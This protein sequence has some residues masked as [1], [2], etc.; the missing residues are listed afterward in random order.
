MKLFVGRH[1][2]TLDAKNRIQI[3]TRFRDVISAE[4]ESQSLY[5]TPGE[6][7][8][9]LSIFTERRFEEL[10][11]RMETEFMATPASRKFEQQFYSL[12]DVV[13]MDKQGRIVLPE[14]LTRMARL[15]GELA[16]VG[17]KHRIDVWSRG[18][19]EQSLGI[20]WEGEEWPEWG[21]FLRMRPG[22]SAAGSRAES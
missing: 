3:P 7:R 16:L 21:D 4:Q 1:D 18:A 11:A 17:Q 12:T 10:A 8:G 9:T 6:S 5:V 2:R 20:D 14:K 19:F 22:G 15:K 13:E